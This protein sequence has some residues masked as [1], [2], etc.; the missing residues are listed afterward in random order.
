MSYPIPEHLREILEPHPKQCTA[1]QVQ[2][3]VRCPCGSYVLS[4]LYVGTRVKNNE[5]PYLEIAEVDGRYIFCVGAKCTDCG[6]EHLLFDDRFHGW[7][8]YV[9]GSDEEQELERPP[10]LEWHCDACDE[11]RHK[12]TLTIQ[13]EDMASLLEE[14]DGFLTE[15]TWHEGFGVFTLDFTC[16]ACN[17]GPTEIV[18]L[19]TM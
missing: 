16:T 11:A 19:E 14:S 18:S 9:C 5:A 15:A 3:S 4:L 7:N 10:F 8:G 2:G 12:I 6:Q 13:G 17:K 1:H